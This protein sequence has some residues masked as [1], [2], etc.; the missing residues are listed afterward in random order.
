MVVKYEIT[1]S[2]GMRSVGIDI[3]DGD[4]A[5][6]VMGPESQRCRD[7]GGG[8]VLPHVNVV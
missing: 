8:T 3:V 2:H 1:I 6:T 4:A 5:I 7:V